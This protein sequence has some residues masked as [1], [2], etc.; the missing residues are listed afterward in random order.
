MSDV[1]LKDLFSN[2]KIAES[3]PLRFEKVLHEPKTLCTKCGA[4]L[5]I[6]RLPWQS[7]CN[8]CQEP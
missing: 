4:E 3:T 6:S 8:K 2:E 5:C 7:R 1:Q